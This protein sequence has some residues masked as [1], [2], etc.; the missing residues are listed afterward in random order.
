MICHIAS[1]F[2]ALRIRFNRNKEDM[3]LYQTIKHLAEFTDICPMEVRRKID[4]MK[5]SGAY[6][7][8]AFLIKPIR[9]DVDAFLHFN[10]YEPLITAGKPFP[11]WRS[12]A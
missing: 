2:F 9:V 10:T 12:G 5:R 6:P 4:R 11:E 8:R 1:L 7:I 3:I